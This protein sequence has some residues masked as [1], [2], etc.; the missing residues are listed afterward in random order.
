MIFLK[1]GG[2]LITDKTQ[3]ETVRQQ[4]LDRLARELAR[5]VVNHGQPI[6]VGHGSGSFGH[7]AA[8]S[9]GTR[10]GVHTPEGWRGF[11][12]VSVAA[13][14]LNRRVSDALHEAGVPIVSLP[15]SASVQCSDGRI[16]SMETRPIQLALQSGLCPLVMGDVAWDS[17]RGGTIVSTEEVFAFL[18]GEF[19]V[20]RVL[21]AGETEGVWHGA[22]RTLV[23]RITSDNWTGLLAD[24]GGSRGAD[25]TGG[26]AGK[27]RDMLSLVRAH[28]RVEVRIFSGLIAGNLERVLAGEP[29]GTEV[30]FGDS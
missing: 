28:P 7:M 12:H 13:A 4:V 18:A 16:T 3:N 6:L 11:A 2:S 25:V 19:P 20:T 17:V 1:L 14:R 30:S 23:E 10:D 27:V 22:D 21:L 29:L 9:Y 8:K 24:V 5:A 26:M 15:P